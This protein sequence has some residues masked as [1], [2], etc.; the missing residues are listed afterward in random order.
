MIT[1]VS[2]SSRVGLYCILSIDHLTTSRYIPLM[3]RSTNVTLVRIPRWK[4]KT[5]VGVGIVSRVP[6]SKVMRSKKR[7]C[8]AI[9]HHVGNAWSLSTKFCSSAFTFTFLLCFGSSITV[10]VGP[11]CIVFTITLVNKRSIRKIV[12]EFH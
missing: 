8:V 9:T 1:K 4:V 3:S 2:Q 7:L 6:I 5:F 10:A 12:I 11:S